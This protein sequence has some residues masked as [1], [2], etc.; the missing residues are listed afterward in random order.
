[1]LGVEPHRII[2]RGRP[3]ARSRSILDEC[4]CCNIGV[5]VDQGTGITVRRD[6]DVGDLGCRTRTSGS[7]LKGWVVGEG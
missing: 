3:V 6:V 4:P 7:I 2:D 1:M 5:E